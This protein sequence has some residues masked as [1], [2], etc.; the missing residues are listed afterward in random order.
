M[1]RLPLAML[2]ASLVALPAAAQDADLVA[3]GEKVFKR[4]AACHTI[5]AGA[6]DGV[7]PAL[8]GVVGRAAGTREGYR[9]SDAMVA[10]GASGLAWDTGTLDAFLADPKAMVKGN[11]MAYAGLKNPKARAAVVAYIEANGGE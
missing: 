7:G 6:T 5:G 1:L 4:C 9:Y 3:A 2:I 10:A 11:K 8:D